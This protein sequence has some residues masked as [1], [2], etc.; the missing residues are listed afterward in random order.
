MFVERD[1]GARDYFQVPLERAHQIYRRAIRRVTGLART[2]RGPSM[3]CT[4]GKV[5]VDDVVE[6]AGERVFALKFL[7]ARDPSWVNRVFF[8]HYDERAT[9]MDELRPAFGARRFFFEEAMDAMHEDGHAQLW[10]P[11]AGLPPAVGEANEPS[12]AVERDGGPSSPPL[13]LPS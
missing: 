5:M 4:P 11:R 9:W 8:A 12:A 2:L 6:I 3:S 10:R 13:S 1:T 7:Q